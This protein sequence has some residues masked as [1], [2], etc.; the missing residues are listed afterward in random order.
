MIVDEDYSVRWKGMNG[1]RIYAMNR[2][3]F[4]H[5]IQDANLTLLPVRAALVLNS[6]L[7]REMFADPRR[8][9]PGPVGLS[10]RYRAA[11]DRVPGLRRSPLRRRRRFVRAR[12]AVTTTR[13]AT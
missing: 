1:H 4:T 12:G 11:G 7:G 2:G 10:A 3:R 13:T 6:M 8:A 9:L 5:G